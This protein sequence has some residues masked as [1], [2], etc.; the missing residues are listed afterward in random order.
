MHKIVL[1]KARTTVSLVS[2]FFLRRIKD[3]AIAERSVV[4]MW[5]SS[6]VDQSLQLSRL[7]GWAGWWGSGQREGSRC[8]VVG[9]RGRDKGRSL[10]FVQHAAGRTRD[11]E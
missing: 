11:D 6:V 5:V 7:R 3:A 4:T 9:R 1:L 2:L 8:I 10:S